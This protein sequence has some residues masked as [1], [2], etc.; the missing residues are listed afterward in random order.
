MSGSRNGFLASAPYSS[1]DESSLAE[2]AVRAA[3]LATAEPFSSA[4]PVGL[5][6]R[7][8]AIGDLLSIS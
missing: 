1:S 5:F 4:N 2:V 8:V 3:M 6:S 7:G